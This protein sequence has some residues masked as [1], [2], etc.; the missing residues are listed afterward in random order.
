MVHH[1]QIM[2]GRCQLDPHGVWFNEDYDKRN[3]AAG[4]AYHNHFHGK[5]FLDMA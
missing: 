3:H 1:Y 5:S 2:V 4:M